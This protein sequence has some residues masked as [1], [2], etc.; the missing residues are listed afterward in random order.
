MKWV[1]VSGWESGLGFRKEDSCAELEGDSQG[2]VYK[3]VIECLSGICEVLGS[4]V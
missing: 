4:M 2:L 3:S 1:A